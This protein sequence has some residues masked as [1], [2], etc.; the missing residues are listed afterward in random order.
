MPTLPV[1]Q[2]YHCNE[3]REL[4]KRCGLS[5]G[6]QICSILLSMHLKSGLT[7]GMAFGGSGL[8]RGMAFG[9]SGLIRG[10]LL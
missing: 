4:Y 3:K 10:G 8:I 5:C 6:K 2:V 7:R 1:F 9:G